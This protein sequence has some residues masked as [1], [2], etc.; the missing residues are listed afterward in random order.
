MIYKY[1]IDELVGDLADVGMD[2]EDDF[3]DDEDE[4]EDEDDEELDE[5]IQKID[6]HKGIIIRFPK[7]SSKLK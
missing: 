3:D 1:Y 6:K 5:P 2:Q 7:I 4:D